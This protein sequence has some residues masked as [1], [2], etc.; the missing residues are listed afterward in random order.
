MLPVIVHKMPWTSSFDVDHERRTVHVLDQS[1]G[2]DTS[3]SCTAA[4]STL[5]NL[6]IDQNTFRVF[7]GKHSELYP[8][9]G[10]RYAVSLER[11]AAPLFGITTRGAHLTVYTHSTTTKSQ[12]P[13]SDGKSKMKIWIPRRSPHL[14]TYPNLLDNTVA[15]GIRANET[16][17]E[18]IL[19]EAQEEASLP[20]ELLS[21]SL[22]AHGTITYMKVTGP[23]A[24]G[25]HGLVHPDVLWVYDMEV[26][27]SVVPKPEDGEVKEFYL[28]GVEEVKERVK[29]GEFKGN[30]AVVMVEFLIRHG[31]VTEETE[32]KE[33]FKGILE[34]MGR[35][36]PF[37]IHGCN[38]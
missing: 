32:G 30:S 18:N 4:F 35:K 17:L 14:N 13:N 38:S 7:N 25:E 23:G 22:K 37:P 12:K 21:S 3:Q 29:R 2:A 6:C 33:E 8:I 15:G 10:S 5:I 34:G 11:F 24:A 1:N 20:P 28:M 36:L 9:P 19:V 31:F 16:P 27:E 26:D